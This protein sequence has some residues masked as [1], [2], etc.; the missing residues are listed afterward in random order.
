MKLT[1]RK[2]IWI[3]SLPAVL[4]VIWSVSGLAPVHA[5]IYGYTDPRGVRHLTNVPPRGDARYELL[6]R[7]AAT[8]P[9]GWSGARYDQSP[10]LD[11]GT[12]DELVRQTARQHGVDPALVRAVIHAESAF[13]PRAVSPK[14]AAGLMQ[15]MPATAD[16][17]GVADVFDPQ[18]NIRGGV[19]Y[20][21]FLLRLFEGDQRLAL[22]AY[23]AGEG[24]VR[25]HHGI[26]P[27]EETVRY[28]SKVT[29]LHQRY[30][31]N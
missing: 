29:E 15:L 26:P 28:V 14:G 3:G 10:R 8:R 6:M 4:A 2:V 23:N 31:S 24:A 11:H 20:L 30:R 7:N 21:A 9:K 18:E 25:K 12:F 16:R 5:D 17:F 1:A 27:Y 19:T 13:D 22:A